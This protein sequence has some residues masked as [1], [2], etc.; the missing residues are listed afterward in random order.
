M[1]KVELMDVWFSYVHQHCQAHWSL[2]LGFQ[3]SRRHRLAQ[4][5]VPLDFDEV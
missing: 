3:R 2:H 4:Y 5:Q 1:T